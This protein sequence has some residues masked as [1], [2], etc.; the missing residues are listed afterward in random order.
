[1]TDLVLLVDPTV[2]EPENNETKKIERSVTLSNEQWSILA[3]CA[4]SY[5][6]TYRAKHSQT[7]ATYV[8]RGQ[9]PEAQAEAVKMNRLLQTLDKLQAKLM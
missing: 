1:M 9:I 5:S 7:I 6:D 4:E 3:M 2:E 8:T